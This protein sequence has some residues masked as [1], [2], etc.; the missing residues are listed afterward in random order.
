MKKLILILFSLMFFCSAALAFEYGD[1]EKQPSAWEGWAER[2]YTE[3]D[4]TIG[5]GKEK[6]EGD[7]I[8]GPGFSSESTLPENAEGEST[9]DVWGF[10]GPEE[11]K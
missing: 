3:D 2:G 6:D 4:K 9:S 5:G 1:A 8:G 7:I 10:A 11:Q